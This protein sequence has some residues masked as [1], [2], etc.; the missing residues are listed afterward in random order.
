[1]ML[2][3]KGGVKGENVNTIFCVPSIS[4]QFIL[5]LPSCKNAKI[6]HL[7]DDKLLNPGMC[8]F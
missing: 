6:L 7:C 4:V 8:D 1:M 3:A 5:P 2:G